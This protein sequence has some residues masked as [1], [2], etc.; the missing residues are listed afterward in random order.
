MV[1]LDNSSPAG[2]RVQAFV[3]VRLLIYVFEPVRLVEC[4]D[5]DHWLW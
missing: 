1:L 3:T 5:P 4:L 2:R